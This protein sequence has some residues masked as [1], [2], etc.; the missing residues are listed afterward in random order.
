MREGSIPVLAF[1]GLSGGYGETI[2]LQEIE[3][4]VAS[5]QILG[6]VGRN[7]VGKT[8]LA[9]LLTGEIPV[10]SGVIHLKDADVTREG[11]WRRRERGLG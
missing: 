3:G 5:G 2:V 8:T 10:E 11:L 7:G 9:R 6:V 4:Q 1:A